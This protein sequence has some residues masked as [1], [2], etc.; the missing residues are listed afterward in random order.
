MTVPITLFDLPHRQAREL[1]AS[2]VPVF[3]TIDPVEY[4]GPHLSL[5]NDRIMS[6]ALLRALHAGLAERAPGLPLVL[7]DAMP[8]G[9]EPVQGPGSHAVPFPVV[10]DL[11]VGAALALADLGAE[12]VV[13]LTSHGAPLHSLAIQHAVRALV[14]RGVRAL[15]PMNVILHALLDPPEALLD[16]AAACVP[17]PEREELR[18]SMQH[19]FHAGFGETSLSLHW[20]PEAVDP[21]HRELPDVNLTTPDATLGRAARIARALG[22]DALARELDYAAHGVGWFKMRPFPGYTGRPRLACAAAGAVFARFA[23]ERILDVTRAVLEEGAAAPEPPMRWLERVS[24]GGRIPGGI[25]P[26]EAVR[27]HPQPGR[28]TA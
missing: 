19:D 4:H 27:L 18:A 13:L 5:H 9:V 12:K 28:S 16:E 22:R 2:G 20:A 10:R 17:E 26:P 23:E 15:A 24:V 21:I 1:L 11:V 14:A 6:R 7:A 25:V 8:I 3:V